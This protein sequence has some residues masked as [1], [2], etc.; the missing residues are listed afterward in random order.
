MNDNDLISDDDDAAFEADVALLWSREG[1]EFAKA[2]DRCGWKITVKDEQ[3]PNTPL[4]GPTG[5]WWMGVRCA[6]C[7]SWADNGELP[8]LEVIDGGRREE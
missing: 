4:Q 6:D 8:R 7:P 2:L 3:D 1:D 5:R